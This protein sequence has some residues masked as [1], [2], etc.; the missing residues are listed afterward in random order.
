MFSVPDQ[1][2]NICYSNGISL[3]LFSCRYMPVTVPLFYSFINDHPVPIKVF[4]CELVN[5]MLIIVEIQ[6]IQSKIYFR[7]WPFLSG[8][9]TTINMAT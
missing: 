6:E 1:M 3:Y 8:Y 4:E 2:S 9:K 7:A 5:L